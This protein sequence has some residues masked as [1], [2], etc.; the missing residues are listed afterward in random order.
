M[1]DAKVIDNNDIKKILAE[2][3]GV[4]ESNILKSQYSYTIIMEGK[5]EEEDNG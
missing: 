1:K 5:E 2:Y 4:P 3:F